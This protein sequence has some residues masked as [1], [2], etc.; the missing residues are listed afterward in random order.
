MDFQYHLT[1]EDYT[2]IQYCRSYKYTK[3]PI[4]LLK[5]TG[6]S[7]GIILVSMIVGFLAMAVLDK[8][9]GFAMMFVIIGF[10]IMIIFL[11]SQRQGGVMLQ[12][13][14][15]FRDER[16]DYYLVQFLRGASCPNTGLKQQYVQ[17]DL[18]KA[19]DTASAYYYV[20]RYNLGYLDYDSM[21]GGE[22]KVLK[23]D[24]L[25]LQKHGSVKSKYTCQIKGK[26]KTLKIANCY[27]GL[28]EEVG[29]R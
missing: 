15:Y 5:T 27:A 7:I 16:G 25:T 26:K 22:A 29:Q 6:I 19:Q 2:N 12:L 28:A 3:K 21:M 9:L 14:Q 18:I 10:V 11:L 8:P 23:L 1:D 17:Q 20:K 24:N 4:P 13:T